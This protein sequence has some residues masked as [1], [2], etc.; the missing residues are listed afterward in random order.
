[1]C[2]ILCVQYVP[3]EYVRVMRIG[4]SHARLP[5]DILVPT[6]LTRWREKHAI[7]RKIQSL[8]II[9]S[10]KYCPRFYYFPRTLRLHYS[11][12]VLYNALKWALSRTGIRNLLRYKDSETCNC[13]VQVLKV[14]IESETH[15]CHHSLRSRNRSKGS[16]RTK[17]DMTWP[18]LSQFS[19]YGYY[20]I[21]F[22]ISSYK[23]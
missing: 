19:R 11:T 16:S 23:I 9:L 5:L 14:R 15:Q 18:H 2:L 22:S 4:K 3:T 8:I 12:Q 20:F 10:N 1:M 21:Y 7:T 17:Y 13:T 6:H